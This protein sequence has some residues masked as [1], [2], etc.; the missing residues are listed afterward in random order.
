MPVDF[1][2][3]V[4]LVIT[5]VCLDS[6]LVV[7]TLSHINQTGNQ[8][9]FDFKIYYGLIDFSQNSIY[10]ASISSSKVASPRCRM[11]K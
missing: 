1:V 5:A 4:W 7:Q 9:Y 6:F 8:L 3:C 10:F 11:D 2:S